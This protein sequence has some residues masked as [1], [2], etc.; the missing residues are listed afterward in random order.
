M[1]N[2]SCE[3]FFLFKKKKFFFSQF[4]YFDARRVEDFRR[5]LLNYLEGMLRAQEKVADEWEAYLP[6][7]RAELDGGGG[8][9]DATKAE[10]DN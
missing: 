2:F 9:G 6:G 8:G 3:K 4:D 1:E 7:V 5:G 10:D